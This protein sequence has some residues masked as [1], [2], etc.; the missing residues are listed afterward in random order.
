VRTRLISGLRKIVRTKRHPI[1]PDSGFP[2]TAVLV[3]LL[4]TACRP[5]TASD[6]PVPSIDAGLG[7][8]TVDF[9]VT[10]AGQNPIYDAK[11]TVRIKYG[12]LGLRRIDLEI[13]TNSNGRARFTRLPEKARKPPLEFVVHYHNRTETVLYWPAVDCHKEYTVKLSPKG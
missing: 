4:L 3:L 6:I 5:L 9:T 2:V 1:G 13:G 7:P 8:C 11:I 12:F 10:D